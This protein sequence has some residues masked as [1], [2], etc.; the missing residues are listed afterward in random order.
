MA[1]LHVDVHHEMYVGAPIMTKW[2]TVSNGGPSEVVIERMTVEQLA[3]SRALAS[4]LHAEADYMTFR[5]F[6]IRWELD[7]RFTTDAAPNFHEYF[8]GEAVHY[9]PTEWLDNLWVVPPHQVLGEN[10]GRNRTL[11]SSRY[12]V[13]PARPL[14]PG[15]SFNS[16]RTFTLL[17]DSDDRARQSLARRQLYRR[18]APQTQENPIFF[19]LTRSDSH[20][21]RAAVDQC[22][23]LGI[24]LLIL[25]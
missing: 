17:Q 6:P 16:F 7:P 10:E 25:S 13:G 19:H 21:I 9:Y 5:M 11:L 15:E 18:M 20:A 14:R 2:V 8:L 3:V 1:G 12:P 4:R 22:A 24:E 23:H